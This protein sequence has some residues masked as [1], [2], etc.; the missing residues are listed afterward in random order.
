MT[1]RLKY[2]L[3][4]LI[5]YFVIRSVR[6]PFMALTADI[7]TNKN[8]LDPSKFYYKGTRKVSNTV[9]PSANGGVNCQ[10]FPETVYKQ[11]PPV[12]AVCKGDNSP[13]YYTFDQ[14]AL[15]G[16]DH[17]P[18]KFQNAF[19]RNRRGQRCM[20]AFGNSYGNGTQVG[21]YGGGP[22][23]NCDGGNNSKWTYDGI[24][25]IST[26]APS[27]CLYHKDG[28]NGSEVAL[29][30]CRASNAAGGKPV[31]SY[32]P[33][34][35]LINNEVNKALTVYNGQYNDDI[36]YVMWDYNGGVNDDQKWD[37]RWGYGPTDYWNFEESLTREP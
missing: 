35:A 31:W 3:I 29:Y 14:S 25:I 19:I 28:N 32:L 1:D 37:I 16:Y 24:N 27:F 8:Q 4:I 11:A 18:M 20:N 2:L 33:N 23:Q 13:N 22:N 12:N 36:K 10:E 26:A 17:R 6:E 7:F 34:G 30:Q 21:Q 5:L 9:T 15:P